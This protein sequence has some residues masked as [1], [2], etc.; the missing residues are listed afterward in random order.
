MLTTLEFATW[1]IMLRAFAFA[2]LLA[3]LLFACWLLL[4]LCLICYLLFVAGVFIFMWLH[5][6]Y[7]S[8]A[9]HIKELA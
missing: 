3:Y 6:L 5:V 8:I 4:L 2:L 1:L 9:A 7:T